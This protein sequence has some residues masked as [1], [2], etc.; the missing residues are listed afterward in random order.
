[1]RARQVQGRHN[2]CSA[3]Q[4]NLATIDVDDT[5]S[6]LRDHLID[7]SEVNCSH[8]LCTLR[9]QVLHGGECDGCQAR[10]RGN[11]PKP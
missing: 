6:P 5:P 10:K 1:M 8:P 2:V 9:L 3:I 4:Q 11:R 7:E